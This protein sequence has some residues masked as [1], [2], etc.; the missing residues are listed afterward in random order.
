MNKDRT[1][2]LEE[3]KISGILKEISNLYKQIRVKL[4]DSVLERNFSLTSFA[5]RIIETYEGETI[6]ED[7]SLAS[8]LFSSKVAKEQL[9]PSDSNP[10]FENSSPLKMVI[11]NSKSS[12]GRVKKL[13]E[14]RENGLNFPTD[15]DVII[16][17]ITALLE[18]CNKIT[19]DNSPFNDDEILN[20]I[21]NLC[22]NLDELKESIDIDENNKNLVELYNSLD[23]RLSKLEQ[24][25]SKMEG[26]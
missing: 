10:I 1:V 19:S 17:E 22:K 20:H 13:L 3:V 4:S 12:I 26:N 16:D 11:L 8:I 25:I 15:S 9:L 21:T 7:D 23:E 14:R 18:I 6:S 2:L 24:S 5:R